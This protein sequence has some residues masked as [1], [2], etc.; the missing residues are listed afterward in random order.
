LNLA[1]DLGASAGLKLS[2]IFEQ[3]EFSE[4]ERFDF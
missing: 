2:D 4:D 3:A 1:A